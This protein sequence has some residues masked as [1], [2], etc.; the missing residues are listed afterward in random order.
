MC[1]KEG[2]Y[3][4][5]YIILYAFDFGCKNA[6]CVIKGGTIRRRLNASNSTTPQQ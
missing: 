1:N 6:L 5:F 2:N 4:I 3:F